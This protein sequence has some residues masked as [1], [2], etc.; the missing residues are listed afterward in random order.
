MDG[1]LATWIENWRNGASGFGD[2]L[3]TYAQTLLLPSRLTQV[4]LTLA[5]IG[6]AWVL[7]RALTPQVDTWMRGLEGRPKWQLR[8][9]I[10]L[11]RR[12]AL[13]LFVALIWLAVGV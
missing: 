12:L 13:I 6:I 11:R 5:L 1:E 4:A 7:G 8:L 2:A 9:L 3:L 10:V